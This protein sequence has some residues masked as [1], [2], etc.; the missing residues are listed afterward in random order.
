M[1]VFPR[2]ISVT[3]M[4]WNGQE[5]TDV[6]H[7]SITAIVLPTGPYSQSVCLDERYWNPAPLEATDTVKKLASTRRPLIDTPAVR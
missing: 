7:I 2:R 4:D 5:V 1:R 3:Q 6:G